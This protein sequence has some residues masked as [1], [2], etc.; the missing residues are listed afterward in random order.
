MRNFQRNSIG[1][2]DIYVFQIE[3][4]NGCRAMMEF[5]GLDNDP[6]RKH[7]YAEVSA[8]I[9]DRTGVVYMPEML[10]DLFANHPELYDGC[11]FNGEFGIAVVVRAVAEILARNLMDDAW[12]ASG[13]FTDEQFGKWFHRFAKNANKAGLHLIAA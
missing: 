2:K 4:G 6:E 12:P 10:D 9:V 7:I 3:D 13:E 5:A 1:D 8:G 11:K